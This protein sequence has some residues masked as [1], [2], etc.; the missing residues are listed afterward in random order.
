VQY[1]K[2]LHNLSLRDRFVAGGKASALGVMMRAGMNVPV[3]FVLLC[4]AF[5]RFIAY[6]NLGGK[7]KG[8]LSNVR[9][10]D[11]K[12]ADK[13]SKQIINLILQG[14]IPDRIS[15]EVYKA[16]SRHHLAEVAVRSSATAEDS[17]SLAWAGLLETYVNVGKDMV[18]ENIKKCWASL[19][20]TRAIF[21]RLENKK[22]RKKISVAVVV[23]KM[24]ASDFAGVA[25]TANPVTGDLSQVVIE[26][27]AGLGG[28]VVSGNI[29]PS[30][31]SID[32]RTNLIFDKLSSCPTITDQH[33]TEL[34]ALSVRL[35]KH[36][37][38][39]CDIEWAIENNSIYL[40][41]CRPITTLPKV[42]RSEPAMVDYI[43]NKKWFTGIR[44]EASLFFYSSKQEGSDK[45]L[46]KW[47]GVLF[48]ESMLV[49]VKKNYPI[50]AF[51]LDQAKL[52]HAAS[53]DKMRHHPKLLDDYI[54]KNNVVWHA[55][56][57]QSDQLSKFIARDRY[58]AGLKK[59]F[60]LISSYK[61]AS[62]QF[63]M[64]FSLGMKL[65]ENIAHIR[66]ADKTLKK[67]GVWRNNIALKE[68]KMG[69]VVYYFL[70]YVLLKRKMQSDPLSI[71]NYSTSRELENWLKY[72]ISGKK[73]IKI[74][75]RRKR[76]GYAY[77]HLRNYKQYV[78]EDKSEIKI[79]S[80]YFKKM[81]QTKKGGADGILSGQTT[82]TSDKVIRGVAIIIKDKSQLPVK[83]GLTRN[84]IIVAIQ[85]T[86]HYIPYAKNA[87]GIITDEGGITCHAAIIAREENKPC[88]IGTKNGTDMI[89]DG[90]IVEMN[91]QNGRV[92]I[93]RK[94]TGR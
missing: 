18:M 20:T 72:V 74:I 90:D 22:L 92:K 86:P 76:D 26:S 65:A 13:A 79:I 19:F 68:E 54:A 56:K 44:A 88:I 16:Y 1:T 70:K 8:I 80:G 85:T 87:K 62:A 23:Q 43:R 49:P 83:G 52:F 48:A 41:Q 69:E 93:I 39:P 77:A 78:I 34:S 32:K 63:N 73:I 5:D 12:S 58:R 9:L 25:F 21:Y 33:A 15:I 47:H 14:Q 27:G 35:E 3:G 82:Q 84:K 94:W 89:K 17:V 75:N 64:I 40:L 37:R 60:V 61:K 30:R 4:T 50:R 46:K 66:G 57:K 11:V 6:N 42:A 53:L 31:F 59:F 91:L 38:F 36:F 71:L 28:K 24:I 67:H 7:I 81:L 55:I 10:K 51:N 29:T 45:Y 2:S